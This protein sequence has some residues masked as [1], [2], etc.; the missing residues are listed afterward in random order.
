MGYKGARQEEVKDTNVGRVA[1][2]SNKNDGLSFNFS[3]MSAFSVA[4]FA[5]LCE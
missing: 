1:S 4:L 5:A 3:F 2:G